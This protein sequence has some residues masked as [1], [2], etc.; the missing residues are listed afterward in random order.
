M[1]EILK[2]LTK[3]LDK[4]LTIKS[5]LTLALLV[6]FGY[7]AVRGVYNEQ[8]NNIFLMVISFYFGTQSN[9]EV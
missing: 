6:L 8:V 2:T 1:K 4:L 7:L 3:R 5:I 9:K